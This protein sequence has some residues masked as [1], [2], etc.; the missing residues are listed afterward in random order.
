MIHTSDC[1][2]RIIAE[3]PAFKT[4][5]DDYLQ[6]WRGES[7]GFSLE[8]SEFARFIHDSIVGD[9]TVDLLKA[10]NLIEEL[11]TKG[12]DEMQDAAAT[13]ILENLQNYETPPKKWIYLL[14]PESRKYCLAWDNFTGV[15]TEGL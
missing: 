7:P 3:F 4:Y 8:L 11:M 12:D 10:F 6:R 15:R 9:G 13:C 14:G 1:I 5:W 2:P